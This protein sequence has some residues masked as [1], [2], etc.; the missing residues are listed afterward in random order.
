MN[1]IVAEQSVRRCQSWCVDHHDGGKYPEDAFCASERVEIAGIETHLSDGTLDDA[2][3]I[4][5][6]QTHYAPESITPAQAGALAR[7]LTELSLWISAPDV[8]LAM[9]EGRAGDALEAA[10][11]HL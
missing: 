9:R 1:N 6:Q 10:A 4:F 3:A 5:V 7:R 8:A 2:P 11:R